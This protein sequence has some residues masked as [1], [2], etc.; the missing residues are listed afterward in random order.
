M[1]QVSPLQSEIHQESHSSYNDTISKI[2]HDEE[3][4][5]RLGINKY[6]SYSLPNHN[7]GYV[8]P[9]KSGLKN[10]VKA[11]MSMFSLNVGKKSNSKSTSSQWNTNSL[12]RASFLF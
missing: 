8:K 1:Y 7:N 10:R 4:L 12:D 5:E 6:D 9:A 3:A 11:S 2:L